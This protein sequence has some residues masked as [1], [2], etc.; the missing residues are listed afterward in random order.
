MPPESSERPALYLDTARLGL[1]SPS[2]QQ[3][4]TNFARLAG[5][6]HGLLYFREFL[7][8][9]AQACPGAWRTRF[10]GFDHWGG[11]QGLA[12]S[13]R[14]LTHASPHA[15]VLF[16]SRSATLMQL[17]A[18]QLVT[19]S[20]RVLTVD[21]LWPPY[22]RLL[23]QACR[24]AGVSVVVSPLRTAALFAGANPDEMAAAVCR[25]YRE[26]GCDG[27]ALPLI[28]HRGITVPVGEIVA[29]LRTSGCVPKQTIVDASQAI[30][31]VPIDVSSLG[32][33][34]LI[35]GAH[36]WIGGYHPLGIGI[37]SG[38]T[39]LK[40]SSAAV[41][42]PLLRLT[43]EAAGRKT[44]RHGETAAILPLL[45]AAGAIADLGG[46]AVE[47]RLNRRLANRTKLTSLLQQ[48]GWQ[49]LRTRTERHGI[50]LAKPPIDLARYAGLMARELFASLGIIVTQYAN[51]MV[52]F[53]L[54]D[55]PLSE[56]DMARL[57]IASLLRDTRHSRG[58]TTP[59]P[60]KGTLPCPTV[61]WTTVR[62]AVSTRPTTEESLTT[63]PTADSIV[64]SVFSR[65]KG[66]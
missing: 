17:A 13:M 38:T 35:G 21:L 63:T 27:L 43:Q 60:M 22:R 4:Q 40:N 39:R 11:V 62:P 58:V 47:E 1:M 12:A 48:A 44:T 53:S 25:A 52:R 50:L 59:L 51:A 37:V 15:E 5:D 54:P 56:F 19:S 65:T 34:W 26:Q 41:S 14:R 10:P 30:G 7:L 9:G 66:S 32:C 24:R 57:R 31:H 18:E 33:D 6:P 28:D 45:T 61:E 29:R 36:K 46:H 55:V 23:A 42:D 16:A 2:A 8:R 20:E 64:G 3:I 49:P